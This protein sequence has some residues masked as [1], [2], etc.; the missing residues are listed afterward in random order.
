MK[1]TEK[2][3]FNI[4]KIN[5]FGSTVKPMYNGHP[6]D[7]KNMA[8]LQRYEKDQW[9]VGFRLVVMASDWPL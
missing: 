3:K 9:L 6:W 5:N 1:F 8:V 2:K 7:L 4:K